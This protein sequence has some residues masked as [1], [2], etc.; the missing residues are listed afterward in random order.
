[1]SFFYL[2]IT[3]YYTKKLKKLQDTVTK[4]K[5]KKKYEKFKV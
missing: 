1:M 2:Y 4:L 3:L 5:K